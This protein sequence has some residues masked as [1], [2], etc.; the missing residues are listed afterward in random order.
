MIGFV[1]SS[2]YFGGDG[3][4]A[5]NFAKIW[6]CPH[7]ST[8]RNQT[9]QLTKIGK[10]YFKRDSLVKNMQI[11]LYQFRRKHGDALHRFQFRASLSSRW[12][13]PRTTH[14]LSGVGRFPGKAQMP[15][16]ALESPPH[17]G[18]V[19]L[20][21]SGWV[22][23]PRH[24]TFLDR[25]RSPR[26]RIGVLYTDRYTIVHRMAPLPSGLTAVMENDGI[27]APSG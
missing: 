10:Y 12:T 20:W 6:H 21:G 2:P 16:K 1:A 5:P 7:S 26:L 4:I 23:S 18:L 3:E 19:I 9:V 17:Y 15:R 22:V 13:A 8:C 24:G 11:F 25:S 14:P 27:A